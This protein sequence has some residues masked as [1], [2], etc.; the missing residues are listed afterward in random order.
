MQNGHGREREKDKQVEKAQKVPIFR[1]EINRNSM[2]RFVSS[3]PLTS[4]WNAFEILSRRFLRLLLRDLGSI[5]VLYYNVPGCLSTFREDVA[6]AGPN[7]H[8][9]YKVLLLQVR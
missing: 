9:R 1:V 6:Y 4:T 2:F 7:V 3:K 5:I 8:I